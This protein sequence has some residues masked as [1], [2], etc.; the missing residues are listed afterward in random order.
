MILSATI[1]R[2]WDDAEALGL[3]CP[4]IADAFHSFWRS[5]GARLSHAEPLD[6]A[7]PGRKGPQHFSSLRPCSLL[8]RVVSALAS[9][10]LPA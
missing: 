5:S 10:L 9:V 8:M 6:S 3:E 2:F 1:Q 7:R 4:A